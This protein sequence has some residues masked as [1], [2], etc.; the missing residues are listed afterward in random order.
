M[1]LLMMFASIQPE[2]PGELMA[3]AGGQ[4]KDKSVFFDVGA[5]DTSS[6]GGPTGEAK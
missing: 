4:I 6:S 2:S 5:G 3:L 1:W